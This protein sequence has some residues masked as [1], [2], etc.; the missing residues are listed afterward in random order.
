MRRILRPSWISCAYVLAVAVLATWGFTGESTAVILLAALLALP[1]SIATVPGYYVAYG[2]LGLVP[3]ANPS[4]STGSSSCSGGGTCRSSSTG[5][6]AS[7][8]AVATDTLGILALTLAAVLNVIMLRIVVTA[9]RR[10][11]GLPR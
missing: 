1:W 6:L 8:F 5:D 9:V 11:A 7:W 4:T 2:L 10:P 3:G